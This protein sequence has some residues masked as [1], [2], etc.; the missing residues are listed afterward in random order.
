MMVFRLRIKIHRKLSKCTN[1]NHQGHI[2]FP[3]LNIRINI[4]AFLLALNILHSLPNYASGKEIERQREREKEIAFCN[5]DLMHSQF[6]NT[7]LFMHRDFTRKKVIAYACSTSPQDDSII[8]KSPKIIHNVY[9][10]IRCKQPFNVE[11]TPR[12][13][14]SKTLVARYVY[15]ALHIGNKVMQNTIL[16]IARFVQS[17]SGRRFVF[18][19]GSP[20]L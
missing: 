11:H 20:R 6:S 12:T 8:L 3:I 15:L 19:R 16:P 17:S 7:S 10:Y 18:P 4:S 5:F 1:I 9:A 14:G 2:I 13:H